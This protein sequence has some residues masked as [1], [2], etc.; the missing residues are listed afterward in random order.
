MP[1]QRAYK[2]LFSEASVPSSV[3]D[4]TSCGTVTLTQRADEN[5]QP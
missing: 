4:Y 1:Q 2:M 3:G 5:I